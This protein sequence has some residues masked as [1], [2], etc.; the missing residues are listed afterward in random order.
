MR[1]VVRPEPRLKVV[2]QFEDLSLDRDIDRG[3]R[4]VSDE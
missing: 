2:K 3:C 4:L 1:I